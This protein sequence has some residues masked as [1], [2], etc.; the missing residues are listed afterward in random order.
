MGRELP[1]NTEVPPCP[2]ALAG[3]RA[4]K[5]DKKSNF[6]VGS[7]G[8]ECAQTHCFY[9]ELVDFCTLLGVNGLIKGQLELD[10]GLLAC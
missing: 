2:R 3:T 8:C 9:S 6:P 5:L 7:L 4:H 10:C 1:P